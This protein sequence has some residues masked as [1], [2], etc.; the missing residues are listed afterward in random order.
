MHFNL[1]HVQ[2]ATIDPSDDGLLEEIAAERRDKDVIT[3]EER[4]DEDALET[5]WNTVEDDIS[6]DSTWFSVG[7]KDE[8]A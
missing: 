8:T 4:S 1:H 6:H 3:L 2:F 7:D 5:Y